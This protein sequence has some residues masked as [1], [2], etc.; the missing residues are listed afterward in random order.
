MKKSFEIYCVKTYKDRDGKDLEDKVLKNS[1]AKLISAG[2]S[3]EH[4]FC[5]ENKFF[6]FVLGETEKIPCDYWLKNST[7]IEFAEAMKLLKNDTIG[8]SDELPEHV[9]D[10]QRR[11]VLVRDEDG[12]TWQDMFLVHDLGENFYERYICVDDEEELS[13]E[14]IRTSEWRQMKE[15]EN[16]EVQVTDTITSEGLKKA[17]KEIREVREADEENEMKRT[18]HTYESFVALNPMWVRIRN[19]VVPVSLIIMTIC[20]DGIFVNTLSNR[21]DFHSLHDMNNFEVISA[22]GTIHPFYQES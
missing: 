1:S 7:E 4:P 19:S 14:E 2:I 3:S 6:Y 22:D 16:E 8:D 17:M 15:V 5:M 12:E 20:D 11:D 18:P 9:W 21:L 10:G 13:E